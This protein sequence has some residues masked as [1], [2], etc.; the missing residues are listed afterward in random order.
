LSE[1]SFPDAEKAQ[2]EAEKQIAAKRKKNYHDGEED[3]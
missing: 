2:K 1:K 3:S